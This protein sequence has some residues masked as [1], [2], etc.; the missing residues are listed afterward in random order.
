MQPGLLLV[1]LGSPASPT[2]R[3]VKQYLQTFL[4]DPSVVEM[5]KA[6]WQ[7]LLRGVILPMRAWRSAT[8][9]RDS[10]LASGSP[11]IVNSRAIQRLVQAQLPTW[12][13]QLAMTY[14]KPAI[15]TTLMA[16]HNRGDTQLV[17]LPLF[18]QYT[19]STHAGIKRQAAATGLPFEFITHF[20]DEPV[21]QDLL[22][23]QIQ[24]SYDRHHYDA[25]VISYH[26]IPTAMVRHGDPY[27]AQCQATTQAMLDR[28]SPAA[29]AKVVTAYQSKFGPMPWLKPYLKNELMQLVEM[30]K[31]NVLV[32]TPS[33]VVDCLETI[34]EDY[35]QNYQTFKACGGDRF[36]L[37]PPMNDDPT[38]SQL[39]A[40]LAKRQLEAVV[41][42]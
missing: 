3:D 38:F 11:L 37:V 16:M 32:A 27:Q 13:V 6:L 29:Q 36:D 23:D 7:P 30:G 42:G 39:L 20:Y 4:S 9:Y 40:T 14:G 28:L 31:R 25:I 17:V 1:N 21:Y 35:V 2:T 24:M 5:P 41:N 10:W 33:F 15:D 22:A 19:Q 8:F 26:S 18:P 12:D 34:E